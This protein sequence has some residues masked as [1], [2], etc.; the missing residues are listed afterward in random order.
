MTSVGVLPFLFAIIFDA[1]CSNNN[2]VTSVLLLD[3]AQWNAVWLS[4]SGLFTSSLSSAIAHERRKCCCK[5]PSALVLLDHCHNQCQRVFQYP[6]SQQSH[7]HHHNGKKCNT[8]AGLISMKEMNIETKQFDVCKTLVH[9]PL[10]S[11]I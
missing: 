1:P 8:S 7:W 2:L 6:A 3:A 4:L 11:V 5:M 9:H 10:C